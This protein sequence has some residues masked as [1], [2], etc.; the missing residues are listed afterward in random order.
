LQEAEQTYTGTFN[1]HRVQHVHLE[2]HAAIAWL[3]EE[4]R[5]VVRTS[6]QTPFLTRDMLAQLFDLPR[7]RVRVLTGRSGGG[8]GAKQELL[9]E[10]VVALAALRTGRPVQLELTREEQFTAATTR[11]PMSVEVTLGAR[12][13]GEL[14]AMRL[15]V[16]AD[17]GAYGNHSAGVLFHSVNESLAVYRCP[18]KQVDAV[19]AYTN[20]VPSGAFRGYGLTQT[21]FAVESAMDELAHQLGIDPVAL[22]R[23]NMIGPADALTSTDAEPSDVTIGSYGLAEC[24]DTVERRLAECAAEPSPDG[25]WLVGSGIALAMLDS[26]PPGG[27]HGRARIAER[28]WGGYLLTVGT[29][30]FGNGTTTVHAQLAAQALGTT[31]DSVQ[32]EQADTALLEHDTGAYGS[33]GTIVAGTATLHAAQ[34]LRLMLDERGPRR[35]G[36]ELLQAEA[37]TAGTPRTVAFNVQGFRVAVSP[38]T[39]EVRILSSVHAADAG[40]VINPRQ[41][42]GQVEGG[43]T[44]ALGAALF[45]HV[46]IDASGRVTTR[47]LREYHIPV[48]GDVPRTEVCTSRR[49]ATSWVR[50]VPSP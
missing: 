38:S 23:R 29:A 21:I 14:T 36:G 24:L 31:P 5:L 16:L 9:V 22:R 10:D 32:V 40:T 45:E 7:E 17:T 50:S 3:D 13:D 4:G 35:P 30:E 2:T 1:T 39:G 8:F 46:D 42:R 34:Q 12:A 18:N 11:H 41:C 48:L 27:H 6:S 43:V 15:R 44:Q 28:A 49:R 37:V 20:T 25:R 47:T 33:T 19:S 26:T